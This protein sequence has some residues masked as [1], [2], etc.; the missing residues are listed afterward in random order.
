MLLDKKG[1]GT[2]AGKLAN[3]CPQ[4]WDGAPLP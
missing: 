1:E 2:D 4:Y 3:K